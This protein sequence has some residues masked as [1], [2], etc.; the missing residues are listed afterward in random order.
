M[1]LSL[2]EANTHEAIARVVSLAGEIWHEHYASFLTAGQI[3]Y[4]LEKYQSVA[5]I[6]HQIEHEHYRYFLL[7][8][9]GG[10]Y[11]GYFGIKP[12]S[13]SLFLS[14]YYILNKYRGKGY[15]S[16][17]FAQME[18]MAQELGL[19]TIWLTV[20][21]NNSDSIA[22]YKHKGFDVIREQVTDIGE[23]YVMNDYVMAKKII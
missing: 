21:K 20:N 4:M 16:A 12:E 1:R 3:D 8:E 19:K 5:A 7:L 22:V 14:K 23:K 15:A 6:T 10:V 17:G 18:K 2:I 11:L 9:Q 13:D